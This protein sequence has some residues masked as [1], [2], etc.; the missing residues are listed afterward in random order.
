MSY[1]D[2]LRGQAARMTCGDELR[3]QILSWKNSVP[4]LKKG[5]GKNSVPSGFGKV[6]RKFGAKR[7]RNFSGLY[8]L[9]MTR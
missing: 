1:Q 9:S 8:F 2:E 4:E 7:R 5:G 6:K 3:G